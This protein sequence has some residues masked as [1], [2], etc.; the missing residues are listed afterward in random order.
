[1]RS[2]ASSVGRNPNP[3][4]AVP[5][6]VAIARGAALAMPPAQAPGPAS[7]AEILRALHD[8]IAPSLAAINL[9]LEVLR[10]RVEVDAPALT[11]EVDYIASLLQDESSKLRILMRRLSPSAAAETAA[12]AGA[13]KRRNS[14][15]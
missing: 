15:R 3:R 2:S 1:M 10:R 6:G 4:E 5:R 12:R 13:R 7:H 14:S 11:G 8:G 9:L